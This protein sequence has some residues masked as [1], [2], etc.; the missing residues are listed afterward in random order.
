MWKWGCHQARSRRSI[1]IAS[2]IVILHAAPR[3]PERAQ[4]QSRREETEVARS[5]RRYYSQ[6]QQE[7]YRHSQEFLA[8]FLNLG[9]GIPSQLV[10]IPS[11]LGTYQEP[12]S[13]QL[14]TFLASQLAQEKPYYQLLGIPSQEIAR[15]SYFFIRNPRNL[16]FLA[17]NSQLELA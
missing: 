16:R 1:Q 3:N 15:N 8:R 13:S 6:D 5:Q 10:R 4:E 14:G 9:E 12:R 17:R 2:T 7:Q 11:Q